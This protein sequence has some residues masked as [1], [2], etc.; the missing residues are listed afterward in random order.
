MLNLMQTCSHLVDPTWSIF[1]IISLF[2]G[3]QHGLLCR[4][5]ILAMAK[6]SVRP[7]VTPLYYVKRG[8]LGLR[9]PYQDF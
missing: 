3:C 7:S 9:N 4:C 8:K 6:V 2:T 1:I 5:P